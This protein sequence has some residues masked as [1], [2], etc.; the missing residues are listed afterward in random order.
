MMHFYAGQE[1][2]MQSSYFPQILENAF[3]QAR[4]SPS[5]PIMEHIQN[6][7]RNRSNQRFWFGGFHLDGATQEVAMKVERSGRLHRQISKFDISRDGNADGPC[8]KT[9][10]SDSFD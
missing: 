3:V 2:L 1:N 10:I 9:E 8:T 5:D 7:F 4:A 6:I